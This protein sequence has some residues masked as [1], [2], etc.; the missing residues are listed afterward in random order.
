MI[1]MRFLLRLAG[2]WMLGMALVLLIMDGTKSMAAN[3]LLITSLGDNWAMLDA[4]SLDGFE[5][6]IATSPVKFIWGPLVQPVLSW[7]GW[8]VLGFAGIVLAFLG[9]SKKDRLNNYTRI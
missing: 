8:A 7:P 1:D 3:A 9:R 2:T 5:Q 4:A 6:L